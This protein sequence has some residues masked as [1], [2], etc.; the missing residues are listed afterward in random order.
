MSVSRAADDCLDPQTLAAFAEGALTQDEIQPVLAHLEHCPRCLYALEQTSKLL[1][2]ASGDAAVHHPSRRGTWWLALAATLA[3]VVAGLIALRLPDRQSPMTRLVSLTS[4]SPR[5]IEP[6]ISGEFAWARYDGP[7]R[8]DAASDTRRMKLAGVAGELV[9]Q[10]ER[11]GSTDAQHAAGIALVLIERPL[12][13]VARLRAAAERAPANARLWSDLA[14]AEYTAALQLVRPSL[15]PEALASADRALSIEPRLPEALF[16][17]AL[18]LERLGLP[19]VARE[20]WERYLA[21]DPSSRWAEEAREHVA[22]LRPTTSE[23]QFRNELPRL[24]AAAL[25]G[26]GVVVKQLVVRYPQQSRAFAEVEHLGRWGAALQSGETRR[27]V[28]AHDR[29]QHRRGAGRDFGRGVAERSRAC[30][31]FRG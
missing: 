16:N 15:Y 18:T 12:D 17:R 30:D 7:M 29:A 21:I 2:E 5:S 23:L 28:A 11:E 24:E 6:R 20:A 26:D 31:R 14:A 10:A 19:L 9:D 3:V 4:G 1:D 27:G 13:A 22:R 25:R 8:G